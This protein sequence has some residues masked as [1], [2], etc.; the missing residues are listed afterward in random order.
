M[1]G[2]SLR[3]L[4][5]G[6]PAFAVPTLAAMLASRHDVVGVVTQ[7]DRPRGRGQRTTDGPVKAAALDA[8]LTVLQPATLK[9][10]SLTVAMHDMAAD[11]GVVTAYG[12]ILPERLL[13]I[14][15]LGM[16]N[17]HASLLPKYRGAAP[18]HRAVIAGER[19]TGVT[20]MRVVKALDA[21]A[22]LAK[23]QTP[24]D[25]DETSEAVEHRLATLGARLLVDTL[26]RLAS[27]PIH[28]EPQDDGAATYAHRLVR[29]DGIIDW[30][31]TAE[32]IHHQAR[33]LHPWPL[34]YTFAEG[35]R[36]IIRRTAWTTTDTGAL[37][38][39]IVTAHGDELAIATGRGLLQVRELQLEGKRPMTPR[40]LLTGYRI[41]PGTRL[42][43][44]P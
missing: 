4:F 42:M 15:P 26:D 43:S 14:P 44:T 6:T 38:G 18:I 22:M 36:W 7:P 31:R 35:R 2:R 21:G 30:S 19:E 10:D 20:I 1:S 25:P 8:G 29:E 12:K 41:A 37:P 40:E 17:V 24:I 28:E 13:A 39:T 11:I 9:D 27:G 33:G 16:I 23:V 5:F 34:A 3:V 32:A